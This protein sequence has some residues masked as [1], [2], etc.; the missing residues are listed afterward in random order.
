VHFDLVDAVLDRGPGSI[1]TLKQV[2]LAEEYLQ[3]HFPGFPILPGVMMLEAM[4]AAA[5]RLVEAETDDPARARL[6][7]AEVRN[8][9]YGAMVRPGDALEVEVTATE[10]DAHGCWKCSGRA[11]VRRHADPAVDGDTA[12]SGRFTMRP[13]P[14]ASARTAAAATP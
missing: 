13:V 9:K 10:A 4:A 1:R 3:D 14:P 11:T 8:V 12:V 7:L 5:R 2:T 6:V